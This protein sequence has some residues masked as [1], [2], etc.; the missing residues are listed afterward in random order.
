MATHVIVQQYQKHFLVVSDVILF[1]L[2]CSWHEVEMTC[3][4][5]VM[6]ALMI[7]DQVLVKVL[8]KLV[9]D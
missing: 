4:R 9:V 8:V 7:V 5:R 6:E 3:S 2:D 1:V